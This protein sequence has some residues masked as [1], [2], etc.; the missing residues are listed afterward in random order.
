MTGY[1]T[2]KENEMA[3]QVEL[4]RR[5][6]LKIRKKLWHLCVMNRHSM[7]KASELHSIVDDLDKLVEYLDRRKK[8]DRRK[9]SCN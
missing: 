5:K 7:L 3:I 6:V 2:I 9:R 8:N 1:I 4:D